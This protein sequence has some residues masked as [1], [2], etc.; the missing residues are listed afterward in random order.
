MAKNKL[1]RFYD[2]EI[3]LD[4]ENTWAVSYGDMVT[5]LLCFFI[6][7]ISISVINPNKYESIKRTVESKVSEQTSIERLEESIE[8]FLASENLEQIVNVE[9]NELGVDISIRDEV[10]FISGS[11]ELNSNSIPLFSQL[12]AVFRNL[13]DSYNFEIE[14]HTDNIPINNVQFPSN[15]YLSTAR[16][17]S[18][19]DLFL[20]SG[21]DDKRFKVQGFSDT[22]PAVPNDSEKNRSLNRRVVIKVR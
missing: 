21:F 18:V 19:L 17:L 7:L 20:L 9:A 22:R 6:L 15:W 5:V 13:P 2:K 8:E 4:E 1:S 10:L 3:A 11:A 14:G 16:A 12:Q